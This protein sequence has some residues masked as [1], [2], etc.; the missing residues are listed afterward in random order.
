[1]PTD[2]PRRRKPPAQASMADSSSSS[3]SEQDER[4]WIIVVS[5]Q[6]ELGSGRY[7]VWEDKPAVKISDDGNT[8]TISA[9]NGR[10]DEEPT[11][12][13]NLRD[14]LTISVGK[15]EHFDSQPVGAR[16]ATDAP[17]VPQ[18]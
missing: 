5:S 8:A 14:T 6:P 15:I 13:V 7:G 1:M 18:G 11:V 4:W 9:R 2:R 16:Q 17:N 12:Y 10:S 3:V